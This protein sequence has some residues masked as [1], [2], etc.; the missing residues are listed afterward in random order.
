MDACRR[1]AETSLEHYGPDLEAIEPMRSFTYRRTAILIAVV[2]IP[3]IVGSGCSSSKKTASGGGGGSTSGGAQTNSSAACSGDPVN[4]M[5]ISTLSGGTAEHP[6]I[7]DSVKAA[8]QQINDVCQLG[9]PVKVTT[10]DDKYNPND[11]AGCA[12]QAVSLKV[13]AVVGQDGEMAEAALPVLKAAGIPEVGF[14]QNGSNASSFANSFPLVWGLTL[15]QGEVATAVSL[16]AKK[17]AL[18]AINSPSTGFLVS[19]TKAAV[20][21]LGGTLVTTV[22]V[23]PKATDLSTGAAQLQQS[24]ADAYIPFLAKGALLQ[25]FNALNQL[26]SKVPVM[27][28]SLTLTPQVISQN[29]TATNGIYVIGQGW[30]PADSSNAGIAQLATEMKAIGKSASEESDFGIAGWSGMHVVADL[31]KGSTTF[32]AATLTQKLNTSGPISRPEISPFD[33]TKPAYAEN[34]SFA[35]LRVFSNQVVVSKIDNGAAKV[36]SGGFVPTT[37]TFTIAG[38]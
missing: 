25:L 20:E 32:D 7:V 27:G 17:I 29:V 31:L 30:P 18:I 34:P 21:S 28:S 33:W 16:G 9:R 6:E 12:R 35:K 26:D 11:S 23:D 8:A 22:Q 14:Y 2:C 1:Q 38:G 10:C 24:G 15:V 36:I 4:I 37:K 19:L 13:V 3:A 5:T